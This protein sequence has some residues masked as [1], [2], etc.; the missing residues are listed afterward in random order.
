MNSETIVTCTVAHPHWEAQLRSLIERHAVE[1]GSVRAAEIL[2]HWD[3]ERGYFVQICPKEML[4]HLAHPLS[5]EPQAI[6]AE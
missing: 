1:T 6:P 5:V 3:L 2:Q 4:P